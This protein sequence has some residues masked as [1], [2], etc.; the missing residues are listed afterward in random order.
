ML[1][2]LSFASSTGL[3]RRRIKEKNMGTID[4]K[5]YHTHTTAN[6]IK[7][8]IGVNFYDDHHLDV[9]RT[10]RNYHAGGYILFSF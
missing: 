8:L 6:H 5:K 1:W 2:L 9:S 7:F 4:K 10:G 3:R